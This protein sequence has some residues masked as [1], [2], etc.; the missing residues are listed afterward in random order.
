MKKFLILAIIGTFV[1]L[2]AASAAGN[3]ESAVQ[4]Q[5]YSDEAVTRDQDDWYCG[6]GPRRGYHHG[7]GY[8]HGGRW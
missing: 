4:S 6:P 2:A 1:P 7:Y 5:A 8:C 3:E